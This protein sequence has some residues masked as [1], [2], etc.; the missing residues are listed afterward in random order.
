MFSFLYSFDRIQSRRHIYLSRKIQF[1]F[2]LNEPCS[3]C[4]VFCS[5]MKKKKIVRKKNSEHRLSR[6]IPCFLWNFF[7]HVSVSINL[8][9][10]I[11]FDVEKNGN[12]F[13][14]TAHP[15]IMIIIVIRINSYFI[16]AIDWPLFL[17]H[18]MHN[19]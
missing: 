16:H 4:S 2:L 17:F 9:S 18:S 1:F 10:S 11:Q 3:A 12:L 5:C 8:F 15:V 6:V 7:V 19:E 14:S 13:N